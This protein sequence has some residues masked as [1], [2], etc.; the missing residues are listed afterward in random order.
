MGCPRWCVQQDIQPLSVGSCLCSAVRDAEREMRGAR[1]STSGLINA[2]SITSE[3]ET[4][5]MAS[6]GSVQHRFGRNQHLFLPVPSIDRD[7]QLH[8]GRV[9]LEWSFT[10]DPG[11][12]EGALNWGQGISTTSVPPP[13]SP[14]VSPL[15]P[16]PFSATRP[17][18]PLIYFFFLMQ[19]LNKSTIT[20]SV[21][22]TEG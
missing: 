20:D 5:V 8:R 12:K 10:G 22:M 17:A 11:G 7:E 19:R 3:M 15:P 2:P 16:N 21:Q 18:E 13:W 4:I 9:P 14:T 6:S 1:R